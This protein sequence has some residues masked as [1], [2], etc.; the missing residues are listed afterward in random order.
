MIQT[1]RAVRPSRSEPSSADRSPGRPALE[2]GD[3]MS[4]EEFERRYWLRPDLRR[5]ELVEGVVYV[6][7]PVRNTHGV[8]TTSIAAWLGA[9]VRGRQGLHIRDNVTVRLDADT[10]VQPDVLLRRDETLGGRSRISGDDFIEGAP[11]LVVEVAL[12]SASIDLNAKMKAYERAGVR[13]Y[14]VW[15]I[16]EGLIDWF[17]LRDGVFVRQSPDEDGMIRSDVFPGLVL[18]V[19]AMLEGDLD[20]VLEVLASAQ[21]PTGDLPTDKS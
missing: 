17:V 2:S 3:V 9:Y 12:S 21:P 8:G 13:E 5:A 10:E 4:R 20:L 11:E 6:A 14:V 15:Q 7:S 16:Y 19:A 18:D 1:E